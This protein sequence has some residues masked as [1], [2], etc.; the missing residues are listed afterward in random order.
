M[1]RD[2]EWESESE[3]M[4][5]FRILGYHICIQYTVCILYVI[6][7]LQFSKLDVV[8][9]KVSLEIM[10]LRTDILRY[11]VEQKSTIQGKL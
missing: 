8:G 9:L 4:R 11:P 6:Q 10:T 7:P 3:K 5:R 2:A 1:F